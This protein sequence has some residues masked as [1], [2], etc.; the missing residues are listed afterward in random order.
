VKITEKGYNKLIERVKVLEATIEKLANELR[1]YRNKN[2]PSSMHAR[3][4]KTTGQE[5][6]AISEQLTLES[7]PEQQILNCHA[8]HSMD[9]IFFLPDSIWLLSKCNTPKQRK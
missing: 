2:T 4:T 5:L 9:Y 3:D 8:V 1:K 6:F 7:V